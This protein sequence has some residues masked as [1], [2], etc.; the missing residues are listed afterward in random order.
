MKMNDEYRIVALRRCRVA[1]RR[2]GSVPVEFNSP[3]T[4]RMQNA[5][6]DPRACS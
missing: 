3:C 6:C 4:L 1:A 5:E 2:R